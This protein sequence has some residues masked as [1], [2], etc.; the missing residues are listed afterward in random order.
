MARPENSTSEE[1]DRY[2]NGTLERFT[3]DIN[4]GENIWKYFSSIANIDFARLHDSLGLGWLKSKELAELI[5]TRWNSKTRRRYRLGRF[6]KRFE[7]IIVCAFGKF[8]T[9]RRV[10]RNTRREEHTERRTQSTVNE[11]ISWCGEKPLILSGIS[12][13]LQRREKS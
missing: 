12:S 2:K 8:R 3:R 10:D 7:I 9:L 6:W 11:I 1:G 13:N 5:Y 4:I